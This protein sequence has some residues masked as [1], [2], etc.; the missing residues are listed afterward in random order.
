M[1]TTCIFRPGGSIY[2][3]K[4]IISAIYFPVHY[5]LWLAGIPHEDDSPQFWALAA[6]FDAS[7]YELMSSTK[8]QQLLNTFYAFY[9]TN[10]ADWDDYLFKPTFL[11]QAVVGM[12]G[13]TAKTY[14]AFLQELVKEIQR[15]RKLNPEMS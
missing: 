12:K 9:Q 4:Q 7:P 2:P 6:V 3:L 11:G 15:L 10:L 1:V 14:E 5:V 13:K 8:D